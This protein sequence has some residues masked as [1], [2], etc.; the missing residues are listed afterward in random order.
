MLSSNPNQQGATSPSHI[1]VYNTAQPQRMAASQHFSSPS[2]AHNKA[3][4]RTSDRD[5]AIRRKFASSELNLNNTAAADR[6]DSRGRRAATPAAIN[7][8]LQRRR[9]TMKKEPQAMVVVQAKPGTVAAMH[10]AIPVILSESTPITEVAR[11]MAGRRVDAVLVTDD[12]GEGILKGI[13]TDK[14]VRRP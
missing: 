2:D 3:K 5:A 8:P 7:S 12:R 4:K 9:S 14:D 6:E 1:P 10:P 11:T 13:V